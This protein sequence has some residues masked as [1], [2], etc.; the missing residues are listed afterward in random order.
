MPILEQGYE[1]YRGPVDGGGTRFLSIAA[2][3]VRRNLRWYTWVFLLSSWFFGNIIEVFVL[4]MSYA[5]AALFGANPDT[6]PPEFP[7][8]ANHPHF[9]GDLM[10][11]QVF[12]ALVMATV[13]GAGEIAEDFRTGALTFYLGRPVTRLDYVLGK[14]VAVSAAVLAVTLLPTLVLFAAQALFEGSWGWL[15]DHARVLPAALGMSLL[16]CV[17]ASGFV[18]GLSGMVKRRRWA[19]VTVAAVLFGLTTVA[20]VLAPPRGWTSDAEQH[21]ATQAVREAKTPEDRKAA[22]G[23]LSDS[24]DPIGSGSKLAEWRALSPGATL[25]AAGRDLFGNPVPS[26]FPAGRHWVF[27]VAFP[28]ALLAVLWKRV[29]AV[30]VVA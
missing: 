21:H 15:R 20:A 28:L 17:F 19:T 16:V 7:I 8:L 3:A 6:I 14:T 24:L 10:A 25:A 30:E 18:L 13:V 11:T 29:R 2:A 5:P 1:P 9:Y 22:Y 27:A 12:W 23:R 4:F 26:N